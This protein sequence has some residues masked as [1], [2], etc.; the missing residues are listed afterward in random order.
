MLL[1]VAPPR[2]AS[3]LHTPGA[4]LLYCCFSF[5]NFS[6]YLCCCFSSA[7]QMDPVSKLFPSASIFLYQS[8]Q[9]NSK[10]FPVTLS[11]YNH[12]QQPQPSML[13]M[14]FKS[15]SVTEPQGYQSLH[16]VPKQGVTKSQRRQM[17]EIVESTLMRLNFLQ[18]LAGNMQIE[19]KIKQTR[20]SPVI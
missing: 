5:Y 4:L 13:R 11:T 15:P 10:L 3:T 2:A 17:S 20:R 1:S 12:F 19:D 9:G 18:C 6:Q 7:A 14:R 16:T 8:S